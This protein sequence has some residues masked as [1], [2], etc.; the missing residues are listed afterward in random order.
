MFLQTFTH[1]VSSPN[2]THQD[3]QTDAPV[4]MCREE[5]REE[6]EEEMKGEKEVQGGQLGRKREG[7]G[8]IT[9]GNGK[10]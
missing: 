1:A 6:E 10:I 4:H 2:E 7:A 5:E 9:E 8:G 3:R